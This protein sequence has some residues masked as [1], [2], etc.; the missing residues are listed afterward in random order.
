M[1]GVNDSRL[2][3]CTSWHNPTIL[4][5]IDTMD[6][7]QHK[8]QQ[9]IM[10]LK[11][12]GQD[13]TTCHAMSPGRNKIPSPLSLQDEQILLFPT[14]PYV[15]PKYSVT[16][17]MGS[18]ALGLTIEAMRVAFNASNEFQ[19][20]PLMPRYEVQVM[21][22][23]AQIEFSKFT[24]RIQAA[25]DNS[26]SEKPAALLISLEECSS[27]HRITCLILIAYGKASKAT[28][29]QHPLRIVFLLDPKAM[30]SWHSNPQVIAPHVGRVGEINLSRWT[31]HACE[32]LLAQ[33]EMSSLRNQGDLLREA[34]E[35][36]YD[37]LVKFVEAC[38]QMKSASGL[39]DLS[40]TFTSLAQLQGKD[41]ERFVTISGM[42]SLP[43]SLPL[44]GQ[45]KEFD[46]LTNFSLDDLYTTIKFMCDEKPDFP[47]T[48]DQADAV[49]RWWAALGVIEENRKQQSKYAD[50]KC[51]VTYGFI[52][53][54]QRAIGEWQSAHLANGRF[55]VAAE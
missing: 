16:L 47:I 55:P 36:W 13:A 20:D 31:Q 14:V 2:N 44:G 45:L 23:S 7:I 24:V 4:Q 15:A 54:I 38:G 25:I 41:F 9:A 51:L 50:R 46:R 21:V 52:P 42:N 49:V 6:D 11:R 27:I 34:T 35:G 5:N 32:S 22:D 3:S 10:G 28:R 8:L 1:A 12:H 33:Q 48:P 53:S 29:L 19:S 18:P 43:W 26:A 40:N 37:H 17:V 30:W 39:A